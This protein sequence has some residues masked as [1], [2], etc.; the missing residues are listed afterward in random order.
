M[1]K[2][3]QRILQARY[4]QGSS[5][6]LSKVAKQLSRSMNSVYKQLERLRTALKKCMET[7]LD[8]EIE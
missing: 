6:D 4:S 1:P 7:K 5:E 8:Q 3:Q 2:T